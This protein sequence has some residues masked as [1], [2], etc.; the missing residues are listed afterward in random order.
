M[1]IPVIIHFPPKLGTWVPGRVGAGV[2]LSGVG[3]LASPL[4]DELLSP[5]FL[6]NPILTRRFSS[7]ADS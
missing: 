7:L 4:V 1:S 3:T 5:Q 6:M 2:V